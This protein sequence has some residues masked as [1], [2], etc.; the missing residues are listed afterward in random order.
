[1]A[2]TSS[3]GAMVDYPPRHHPVFFL[4]DALADLAVPTTFARD[5]RTEGC[6]GLVFPNG[7]IMVW[8]IDNRWPHEREKEDP[9]AARLLERGALVA[10]AQKPDYA[11]VGGRW[12]P[13][14]ATPGYEYLPRPKT[15]DV[16]FVGVVRDAQRSTIL[17]DVGAYARLYVGENVFGG[18]AVNAYRSAVLGLNVVT[19]YGHPDAYDSANM[20]LYEVMATGTPVLT[21][22]QPYL[23]D[24]GLQSGYNCFT[25]HNANEL[26]PLVKG[27]VS[28]PRLAEIVGMR[29]A[30]LIQ[31]R[32]T[33]AHRARQVIKWLFG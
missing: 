23:H 5:E 4:Q 21:P 2:G 33:Y 25:Y 7:R 3:V 17:T 16:A 31:E 1:M 14:A 28:D 20:R 11:R 15:H 12:L 22:Y 29:G 26:V 6:W 9:A 30:R 32:H 13:L 10:H 18:D 8:L 19:N 24:L 27:I